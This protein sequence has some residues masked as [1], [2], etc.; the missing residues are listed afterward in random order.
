M[1]AVSE[2]LIRLSVCY[3]IGILFLL[4]FNFFEPQFKIYFWHVWI[5]GSV[6]EIW[7]RTGHLDSKYKTDKKK[8]NNN[9][10]SDN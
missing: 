9:E 5:T 8:E 2:S 6:I 4:G 10:H 7:W 1:D 3:I